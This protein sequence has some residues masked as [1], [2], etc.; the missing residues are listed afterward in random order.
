MTRIFKPD[1]GQTLEIQDEGGSPALTIDTDGDIQVANNIDTGTFNGTMG[2][3]ATG[4][5]LITHADQWRITADITTVGDITTNW[6][7][8]DTDSYSQIGTAMTESSGIFTFPTT[9]TWLITCQGLAEGTNGAITYAGVYIRVTTNAA[10][11]ND[12]FNRAIG[13]CGLYTTGHYVNT[14]CSLIF[15]VTSTSNCKCVFYFS[16]PSEHVK[17]ACGTNTNYNSA[18]FIRLGDN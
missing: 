11:D 17:L 12:Y 14:K 4:F 9:G 10:G 16:R 7:Q 3:S 13:L 15:N 5:G 6:E 2:T 1:S 8:V 18:T